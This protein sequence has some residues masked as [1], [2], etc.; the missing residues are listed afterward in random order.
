MRGPPRLAGVGV[1]R[2]LHHFRGRQLEDM[3]AILAHRLFVPNACG[4][5][6]I[7]NYSI[8]QLTDISY[9]WVP[10]CGLQDKKG[11]FY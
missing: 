9:L 1:P 8:W 2:D 7:W 11:E 4:C 6:N 3:I 10:P 5:G